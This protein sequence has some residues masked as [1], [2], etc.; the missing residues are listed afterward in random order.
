MGTAA[1]TSSVRRLLSKFVM[2]YNK[3]TVL[4]TITVNTMSI[5][6]RKIQSVRNALETIV[7]TFEEI[8]ATS[9]NS[10]KNTKG[11]RERVDGIINRNTEL[12]A[13]LENKVEDIRIVERDSDTLERLFEDLT[14]R[15]K[16]V[17]EI[18]SQIQDVSERTNVLAINASI[19]AARAGEAGKGFRVIAGEVKKL[20]NQTNDFAEDIS[21]TML[22]FDQVTH[23]V[24][25]Y[26]MRFS[27]VMRDLLESIQETQRS[28]TQTNQEQTSTGNAIAEIAAAAEEQD[29]AIQEGLQA[30]EETFSSLEDSYNVSGALR[31]AY[32]NIG[33]VLELV[34]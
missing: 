31:T 22:E 26:I 14:G 21:R 3:S 15:A 16:K 9:Q 11:I 6:Q 33:K 25:E 30:L 13:A 19:E 20:A 5:V 4:H 24:A 28:F 23:E 2:G 10:A 1:N 32:E 7:A 17:G 18:S 8:R 12:S 34:R 27:Q 29:I